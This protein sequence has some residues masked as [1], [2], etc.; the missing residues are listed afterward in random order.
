MKEYEKNNNEHRDFRY[1][2]S[3]DD[4][5]PVSRNEFLQDFIA[6]SMIE[7][8][9]EIISGKEMTAKNIT[10]KISKYLIDWSSQTGDQVINAKAMLLQCWLT[11]NYGE[12]DSIIDDEESMECLE[13]EI[14]S[15]INKIIK[16]K[17]DN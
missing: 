2:L 7:I 8:G 11:A 12:D 13:S 15:G 6:E 9:E 16:A 3:E 1:F 14:Y 4:K 5:E 17:N 10:D